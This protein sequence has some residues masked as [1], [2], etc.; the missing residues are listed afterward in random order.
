MPL[1]EEEPG[2]TDHFLAAAVAGDE[3]QCEVLPGRSAA[4]QSDTCPHREM[5]N[6]SQSEAYG[7]ERPFISPSLWQL[8]SASDLIS[9]G[10]SDQGPL[11]ERRHQRSGGRT[12]YGDLDANGQPATRHGQ[13]EVTMSQIT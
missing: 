13:R 11:L 8:W 4:G 1:I 9:H 6:G 5:A 10:Q 7:G 3:D 2:N 12:Y